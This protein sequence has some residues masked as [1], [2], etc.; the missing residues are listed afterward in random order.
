MIWHRLESGGEMSIDLVT[1]T[2]ASQRVDGESAH[3]GRCR[4]TDVRSD[5]VDTVLVRRAERR[6]RVPAATTRS[7]ALQRALVRICHTPCRHALTRRSCLRHYSS[8]RVT[9]KNRASGLVETKSLYTEWHL[10]ICHSSCADVFLH[11]KDDVSCVL[12]VAA[13]LTFLVSDL[14]LMENGRLPTLA[15]LL[16]THHLAI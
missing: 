12:L 4:L 9:N 15:H 8:C 13:I 10:V 14:P 1:Y 3:T 2:A 5:G 6:R 7:R 16:G 11:F